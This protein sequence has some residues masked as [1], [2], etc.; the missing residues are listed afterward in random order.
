MRPVLGAL[1]SDPQLGLRYWN[2]YECPVRQLRIPEDRWCQWPWLQW[3]SR[4]APIK[5]RA[6]SETACGSE[7]RFPK[8]SSALWLSHKISSIS[9]SGPLFSG[10]FWLCKMCG[11]TWLVASGHNRKSHSP[12]WVGFPR[13]LFPFHQVLWLKCP[14]SSHCPTDYKCWWAQQ[15]TYYSFMEVQCSSGDTANW[16]PH[17][18]LGHLRAAVTVSGWVPAGAS[19]ITQHLTGSVSLCFD[20][21][22]RTRNKD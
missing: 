17:F 3:L 10:P 13:R 2:R 1:R 12:W 8:R 18:P 5:A 19:T 20:P 6:L 7:Y 15:A 16:G 14:R 11:S 9:S 22:E 21:L 4:T